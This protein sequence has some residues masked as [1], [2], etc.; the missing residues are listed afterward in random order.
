MASLF[1]NGSANSQ[2]SHD[3]RVP[4]DAAALAAGWA[5]LPASHA[6]PVGC[7]IAGGSRSLLSA[8]RDQPLRKFRSCDLR[9]CFLKEL[10]QHF[11]NI[12]SYCRISDDLGDEVDDPRLS[13][14]TTGSVGAGT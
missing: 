12:Y 14:A 10:H 9:F 4:I 3:V 6:I 11:F 5:K 1:S 2:T 8:T 13:L 7:S